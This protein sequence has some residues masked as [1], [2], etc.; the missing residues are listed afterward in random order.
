[1]GN[2]KPAGAPVQRFP[3]RL[4]EPEYQQLRK[5]AFDESRHMNDV[6]RDALYDYLQKPKM[7]RE[8]A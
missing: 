4:T 8:P 6:M 3:L 2:S 5:R 1:M 7:V